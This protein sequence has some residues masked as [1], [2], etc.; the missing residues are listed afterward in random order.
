M[1]RV[2]LLLVALTFIA[3]AT[4]R[5]I[6]MYDSDVFVSAMHWSVRSKNTVRILRNLNMVIADIPEEELHLYEA[7]PGTTVV[8]DGEVSIMDGPDFVEKNPLNWGI[9]R[10]DQ[11]NLPLDQAYH[12]RVLAGGVNV[13]VVDTG[14]NAEHIEFGGRA[15][16]DG[17]YA[18]DGKDTDCNGHGTHCASTIAG[19]TVGVAKEAKIFGVKVL[20]CGGSGTWSGVISGIEHVVQKHIASSNKKTVISMSLG[21]GKNIALNAAVEAAWLAGITVVVAAGND[22]ADACNY[23]PASAPSVITV[24]ASDNKDTSAYFTNWGKCTD[25]YAPGV[26]IYAAWIGGT[27]KYNTISGTSMATPHVAGVSA[28]LLGSGAAAKPAEVKAKLVANGT[29]SVLK[30]VPANTPNILLFHDAAATNSV[31]QL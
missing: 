2:I 23:S 19:T 18:G 15:V 6:V 21:G 29:P 20:N 30:N 27:N 1:L 31:F 8:K 7:L 13:Y 3:S 25:I 22:N 10:L 26:N 24:A 4:Q 9:D 17:N 5:Y 16:F 12:F 11:K 14:V 28:L